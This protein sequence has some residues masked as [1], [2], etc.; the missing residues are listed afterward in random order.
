MNPIV[1]VIIPV[2]NQEKYLDECLSSVCG[3][4]LRDIEIMCVNDG[5]TDESL[6]ILNKYAKNDSRI[7]VFSQSNQGAGVARNLGLSKAKGK[8]LSFLDSDDVVNAN[9]KVSHFRP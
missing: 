5:S 6:K 7:H 8:Y 2:Y 9:I 3:Q 4:T 1:S